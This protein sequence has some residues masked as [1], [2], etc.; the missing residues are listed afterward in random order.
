MRLATKLLAIGRRM[1]R[2]A[3]VT[4]ALSASGCGTA[5][6]P[7]KPVDP[8][9]GMN[10]ALGGNSYW[11]REYPFLDRARTAHPFKPQDFNSRNMD[12][13]RVEVDANGYPVRMPAGASL[14]YTLVGLDP[15]ALPTPDRYLITWSGKLSLTLR[16]TRTIKRE[17][18]RML[19]EVN[20]DQTD[21]ILEF[22]SLDP[23][24]PLRDLH[25]VREDQ[26]AL[27]QSGKVFNPAFVEKTR[28]WRAARMMDWGATN[29]NRL[30]HWED[31]VRPEAFSWGEMVPLE[32]MIALANEAG[33]D[34]WYNIPAEADDDYVRRA[35]TMIHDD[36]APGRSLYLEYS[37]E[38]WNWAFAQSN[39]ALDQGR[40]RFGGRDTNGDGRFDGQDQDGG[41]E[42]DWMLFYGL[43]AAQIAHMAREIYAADRARLSNVFSSQTGWRGMEKYGLAGVARAGLGSVDELFDVYAITT[44]F[45]G[46][47]MG[48]TAADR[49]LVLGWARSG[50]AGL[51]AAFLQLR[52]GGMLRE[53]D[54]IDEVRENSAYFGAIA[55]QHGLRLVAYEGGLHLNAVQY[56][57]EDQDEI[58]AFFTR[59]T[60]DP[61]MGELYTEMV[62][63]FGAE[64]GDLLMVF[65]DAGPPNKF[66]LWGTLDSIYDTGS[67]RFDAL[68]AAAAKAAQ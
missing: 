38:V 30:K 43:R 33:V 36:L 24:D 21:N 67:P 63:N 11:G 47:L 50:G 6:P 52:H 34:L 39:Y 68:K 32:I 4:S 29:G 19:V 16:G 64:G 59:L 42:G 45:S 28:L 66:G 46:G 31:R 40:R 5:A 10:L 20:T 23:Q 56:P 3:A 58:V 41:V 48:G 18:N 57:A 14:M 54:T 22:R 51:D 35:V 17:K 8:A 15:R 2:L 12:E 62:G 55:R 9:I 25:I 1:L 13:V 60:A 7:A 53:R 61:R 65:N 37:N 27:W 26:L 44:Y 49:P